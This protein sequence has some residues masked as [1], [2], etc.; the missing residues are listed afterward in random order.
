V[1]HHIA[2]N[3]LIPALSEE[4]TLFPRAKTTD[5]L[6]D[7]KRKSA[8]KRSEA[9]Q[10]M[11]AQCMRAQAAVLSL[12]IALHSI[13]IVAVMVLFFIILIGVINTLRMTVRNAQERL[14]KRAIG[15]AEK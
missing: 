7:C 3:P 12:N 6:T 10:L 15:Y 2:S 9:H 1:A 4:W 5:E 11:C 13:T 14:V 8:A